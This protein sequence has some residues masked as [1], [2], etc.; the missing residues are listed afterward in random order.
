[1]F[2]KIKAVSMRFKILLSCVGCMILAL[3]FQTLLFQR[4]SSEIIY[5]Q[6][7]EISSSTL[8]NLRDDL[9]TFNKSIE[10]NL[11]K[12]YN[13]SEFIRGLAY[14]QA[15]ENPQYSQMAYDLAYNA[16]NP[17]Q[18]I[19][20]LYIY[21]P[22][23]TLIS[24]YRHAQTPKYNYPEDIFSDSMK[25]NTEILEEYALSDERVMLITSYYNTSRQVNLI[26]YVLKIYRNTSDFIGYIVCDTDP[27]PL[28]RL[29]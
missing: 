6:A 18:N 7:Y 1:M 22:E 12:V 26:R 10:N 4:S 17:S 23:H 8:S 28:L 5:A 11:I 27:K 2:V 24:S 13:Q 19:T 16:F 3:V 9:Y 25:I 29:M 14:N 15:A 20:A 21:T